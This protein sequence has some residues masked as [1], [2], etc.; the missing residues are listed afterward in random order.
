ML[1]DVINVKQLLIDGAFCLPEDSVPKTNVLTPGG[2]V[3]PVRLAILTCMCVVRVYGG[4]RGRG[5]GVCVVRVDRGR[6]VG[7]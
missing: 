3:R 7:T 1:D 6:R 5:V 2:A 4:R